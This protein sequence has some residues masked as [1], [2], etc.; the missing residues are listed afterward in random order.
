[1]H[2]GPLRGPFFVDKYFCYLVQIR[3]GPEFQDFNWST[4]S[5]SGGSKMLLQGS[6][7]VDDVF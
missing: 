3:A 4:I 7:F 1:M 2:L 5:G 6:L